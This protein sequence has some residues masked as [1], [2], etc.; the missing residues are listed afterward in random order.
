MP[1]TCTVK[2]ADVRDQYEW[3]PEWSRRARG[4]ALYTLLRALGRNGIVDMMGRCCDLTRSSSGTCHPAAD[5][6]Q[7]ALT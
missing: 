1:A 6:A 4:T 5:I 3:Q 7:A 2:V